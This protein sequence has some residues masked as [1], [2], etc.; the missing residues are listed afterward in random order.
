M[1]ARYHSYHT[2]DG[3]QQPTKHWNSIHKDGHGSAKT[4]EYKSPRRKM[5]RPLVNAAFILSQA[6][7]V[8]ASTSQALY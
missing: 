4:T 1:E 2:K 6:I 7:Y 5:S 3:L 8:T